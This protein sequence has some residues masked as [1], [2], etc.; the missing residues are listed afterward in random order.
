[1]TKSKRS[2]LILIAM[3]MIIVF[4]V[5]SVFI[6]YGVL[7][8]SKVPI[9]STVSIH[10]IGNDVTSIS[11]SQI[12]Q[13]LVFSEPGDK[14]DIPL[15]LLNLSPHIFHYY[16]KLSLKDNTGL[17]N[18]I[19]V[20]LD[21]EFAGTLGAL[22]S[23]GTAIDNGRFIMGA[24]GGANPT[25]KHVLTF[26]LHAAAQGTY[27]A[28]KTV[29]VTVESYAK[30]TNYQTDIFVADN[31]DDF[32]NAVNDVNYGETPYI[33]RLTENITL[34][35]SYALLNPCSIDLMGN[36]L[37]FNGFD[38]VL[39]QSG[40]VKLFSSE[41]TE[42]TSLVEGAG[43]FVLD[44][45]N[46]SFDIKDFVYKEKDEYGKEINTALL[47]SAKVGINSLEGVKLFDAEAAKN[48]MTGRFSQ[49]IKAGLKGGQSADVLGALIFYKTAGGLEITPNEADYGYDGV[50]AKITAPAEVIRTYL[51][52]IDIA[53]TSVEFKINGKDD[54]SALGALLANELGHIPTSFID[55]GTQ[56][57]VVP[58]VTSDLFLPTFVRQ[59]NASVTWWSSNPTLMTA[60]GKIGDTARGDVSLVATVHIGNSVYTSVF[61]FMVYRQDN[62]MKFQYLLALM[63]PI[64]LGEIYDPGDPGSVHAL[65]VVDSESANDYR[66]LY[67]GGN[68]LGL[69]GLEYS[70]EPVYYFLQIA[71]TDHDDYDN[72][73]Y[74]TQPTFQVFAQIQVTGHFGAEEYYGTVNVEIEL[75]SNTELQNMVY[76]YVQ[77]K[78]NETN[79]LK[80]I[81]ETR[82]EN[83]MANEKGDFVLPSSYMGFTITYDIPTVKNSLQRIVNIRNPED[84]TYKALINWAMGG[85]SG[86]AAESVAEGQD[87]SV[88]ALVSD[89]QPTVSE[90]E[91]AAILSYTASK[92]YLGYPEEWE[93]YI[94]G[95]Q[96]SLN[97]DLANGIISSITDLGNGTVLVAVNPIKF[98]SVDTEI[99][100]DVTVFLV[101]GE[102]GVDTRPLTF[103]TP[104]TLHIDKQGFSNIQIFRS[105][106][107]QVWQQLPMDEKIGLPSFED[108]TITFED[109]DL[110]K[111]LLVRDMGYAKTLAFQNGS[112]KDIF[113]ALLGWAKADES[114]KVKASE[115]APDI[116]PSVADNM[117]DGK[118]YIS[119]EEE[120]AIKAFFNQF[121]PEQYDDFISHWDDATTQAYDFEGRNGD[122]DTELDALI[123]RCFEDT[124]AGYILP[125]PKGSATVDHIDEFLNWAT[126][127]PN[128]LDELLGL[129]KMSDSGITLAHNNSTQSDK[130]DTISQGEG[131][132]IIAAYAGFG[133]NELGTAWSTAMSDMGYSYDTW[134]FTLA[135]R[136][137]FKNALLAAMKTKV[138]AAHDEVIEWA[139]SGTADPVSGI[140]TYLS[141]TNADSRATVSLEEAALIK[142]FWTKVSGENTEFDAIW[143][144][145]VPSVKVFTETGEG[146]V[147]SFVAGLMQ[148][149]EQDVLGIENQI[150][151]GMDAVLAQGY[152]EKIG[153]YYFYIGDTTP[154]YIQNNVYRLDYSQGVFGFE[155]INTVVLGTEQAMQ[156]ALDDA[157]GLQ[158]QDEGDA[159]LYTGDMGVYEKNFIYVLRYNLRY[160]SETEEYYREYYFEKAQKPC[161]VSEAG[162]AIPLYYL[163][164]TD[165]NTL[166]GSEGE[167]AERGLMRMKNLTRLS[168]LGSAG[169]YTRIFSSAMNSLKFFNSIADGNGTLKTLELINADLTDISE[170]YKLSNLVHLDLSGNGN[171]IRISA[172]KKLVTDKLKHL[173]VSGTNISLDYSM[174]VLDAIYYDYYNNPDNLEGS[175]PVAPEIW[176]TQAGERTLLNPG[177]APDKQEALKYLYYLKEITE[178]KTEKMLIPSKVYD[179]VSG[180]AVEYGVTWQV[181]SGQ[182]AVSS[183]AIVKDPGGSGVAV[184]SATVTVNGDSYTRYFIITLRG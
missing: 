27:Y 106:K 112:D 140:R 24:A 158:I 88:A 159:Y 18:A 148:S 69:T 166:A 126:K 161:F 38:I 152:S 170:V 62:E 60:S 163:Y 138:G 149:A 74:L 127:V 165:L 133:M 174:H 15:E 93:K 160:D 139:T 53:G 84:D 46:A 90:D 73:L 75:G 28:D 167:A 113:S 184:I 107:L 20:Y 4:V 128:W 97:Y 129:I 50:S 32:I 172:L 49:K 63:N 35:R 80:N 66:V 36:K 61:S 44:S 22:A 135:D 52:S 99:P 141:G 68:D 118:S 10:T 173:D 175:N 102:Q 1:M 71:D 124:A 132:A 21:G 122:Y 65:P 42:Y 11:I 85:V 162:G 103:S 96:R 54:E 34:T 134:G 157:N 154:D 59:K 145:N 125:Y 29:K 48:L 43:G 19:L 45:V 41:K 13:S 92:N 7:F 16:Y 120:A 146:E 77:T 136:T 70:V 171:L 79:I 176:Y 72:D 116:D 178:I 142:V 101:G 105:V 83:G 144:N 9:D 39:R 177:L 180:A 108:G 131:D 40:T 76:A 14:I 123:N 119:L 6:V 153:T 98:Y 181:V 23:G 81:I 25:K 55:P 5:S 109:A 89:G 114:V 115:V 26:E 110:W 37:D 104:A 169:R 121:F 8:S 33:I 137:G 100:I 156:A 143:N 147:N 179:Y 82:I 51:T 150:S 58:E 91:E 87:Q 94:T 182:A 111:Y 57:L 17:E 30:T 183:G 64:S 56:E 3:V 117:S 78:L 168:V 130:K 95:T 86:I 31:E 2:A 155:N 67:T 12:P 151:I 164:V 47:Y